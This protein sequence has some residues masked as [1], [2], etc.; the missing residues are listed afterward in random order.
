MNII[1]KYCNILVFYYKSC[2]F[3]VVCISAHVWIKNY[4]EHKK[5]YLEKC[6]RNYL[7]NGIP[8]LQYYAIK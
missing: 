1:L 5:T 4:H 8:Y 3:E 7:G 2:N 6:N